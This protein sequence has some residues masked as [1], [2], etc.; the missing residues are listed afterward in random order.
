MSTTEPASTQAPERLTWEEIC[1]RY[2]DEWVVLTEIDFI[3]E[4]DEEFRTAVVL[5]H[6]KKRGEAL[7]RVVLPE[8]CC[9]AHFYTG[10]LFPPGP[11]ALRFLGL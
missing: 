2:P 1:A 7:R 4:D 3:E 8:G 9:F 11:F 5:D 10:P 6:S